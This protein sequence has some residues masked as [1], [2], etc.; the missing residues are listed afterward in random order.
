MECHGCLFGSIYKER[1]RKHSE[2]V[3]F[4]IFWMAILN[5]LL[6]SW[7]LL[8]IDNSNFMNKNPYQVTACNV[9]FFHRVSTYMTRRQEEWVGLLCLMSL[10]YK[11]KHTVHRSSVPNEAGMQG[12]LSP[13]W[14]TLERELSLSDTCTYSIYTLATLFWT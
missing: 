12:H 9:H 4:R 6:G 13:L 2:T 3:G 14:G 1:Q 11:H 7:D 5:C 10:H 8:A